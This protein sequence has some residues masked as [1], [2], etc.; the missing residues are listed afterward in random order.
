MSPEEKRDWEESAFEPKVEPKV[1]P[2]VT[3]VGIISVLYSVHRDVYRVPSLG[4]DLW[5]SVEIFGGTVSSGAYIQTADNKGWRLVYHGNYVPG[6][7]VPY[8]ADDPLV[9]DY[10][11]LVKAQ[12]L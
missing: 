10:M 12:K 5:L 3:S 4:S 6:A 8:P 1:E 9:I 11:R 2:E 7:I